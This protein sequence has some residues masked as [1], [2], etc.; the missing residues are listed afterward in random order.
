[1]DDSLARFV[2]DLIG[3]VDGPMHF[4]VYLQPLMACAFAIRDGRRD[5]REGRP[6]YL[7]TVL[8]DPAHRRWLLRNGWKGVWRVFVL[9]WTLDIVYQLFVLGGLQPFQA[10]STAI[11]LALVPYLLLRGP[12]N[13]LARRRMRA[14]AR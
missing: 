2:T 10:L 1:V 11:L 8:T 7:W 5:A 14:V 6:P 9:A 3:R 4:R 12:V 13:R